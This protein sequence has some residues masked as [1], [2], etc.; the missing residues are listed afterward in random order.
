MTQFNNLREEA[1]Y[2]IFKKKYYEALNA[3]EKSIEAVSIASYNA[4]SKEVGSRY[5]NLKFINDNNFIFFSNYNSPKSIEFN[6]HD[7][8]AA[9][10]YWRSINTQIRIKASIQKTSSEFNRKYFYERSS[11]KNAL[12]ISSNQS[13]KIDS[14]ESVISKYRKSLEIEELNKC[15]DYWGG[16]SFT[17]YCFEFWEGHKSRLNKRDLYKL[18]NKG[19]WNHSLLEP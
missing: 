12:A 3:D 1:P 2:L 17:P 6:T 19:I 5:V 8:I 4:I 15:P 10:F 16:Y 13:Q 7:Q 14:Y 9:S 11:K 18:N